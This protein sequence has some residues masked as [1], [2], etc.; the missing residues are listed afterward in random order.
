MK[1]KNLSKKPLVVVSIIIIMYSILAGLYVISVETH[2]NNDTHIYLSEVT[3]QGVKI[4]KSQIEAQFQVVKSIARSIES[5]SI[6]NEYEIINILS[7]ELNESSF[8]RMGIIYPDGKGV[9]SDGYRLDLGDRKY[10]KEAMKGKTTISNPLED[11]VDGNLVN[12]YATPLYKDNEIHAVL[13]ATHSTNVFKELLSVESFGEEGYSY[14]IKSDGSVVVSSN[15]P[16]SVKNFNNVLD[17]L[18]DELKEKSPDQK[19]FMKNLKSGKSGNIAYTHNRIKRYMSYEPIGIND[20]YIATVVPSY[21]ISEK[22]DYIIKSV[23]I[24]A[25]VTIILFA[26]LLFYILLINKKSKKALEEIAFTDRLTGYSNWNKFSIDASKLLKNTNNE[27]AMVLLDV[28]KFKLINDLFGQ[29]KGNNTLKYISQVIDS[30]IRHGETF[31]RISNDTF[32]ILMKYRNNNEIIGRIKCIEESINNYYDHY[33]MLLS[34]G[35]YMITNRDIDINIISDRANLAKRTVKNKTDITYAFYTDVIR[36]NILREKEIENT[37]EEALFNNEF[38]V[39]LQPKY[40]L[41]DESLLGA[42]ALVRWVTKE[43]DIIPPNDFIPIFEKNGFIKRLDMYVFENVCDFLK[44]LRLKGIENLPTLSINLS[45]VHLSDICIAQKLQRIIKRYDVDAKN[46]E[47]E[48][49]ESA[50]FNNE[51]QLISIMRELREVGFKISIDDFGSGYSSLNI[52]KDLPADILKL[53]KAFLDRASDVRGEKIIENIINMS[54][55]LDLYT[56]AEGVETVEQVNFLKKIGCDLAQGYYYA[57][58]MPMEEFRE[59]LY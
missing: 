7:Y 14:I 1:N 54:K 29:E 26:M 2:V 10:F 53:D 20:W 51:K 49:T 44:Y 39:F 31:S 45:R 19:E 18:D 55:D 50:V 4:V 48:L 42:E 52:L 47:I 36:D 35:V 22:S 40:R 17:L 32:G 9:M 56:V 59:Y 25:I 24:L 37:M 3:K 41:K 58:P 6:F 8:K 34:F 23:F 27:Y 16:N 33:R 38:K 13:L 43:G 30:N 11:R 57:K 5:H 12:V 21:V 15:H 28:D 46:I